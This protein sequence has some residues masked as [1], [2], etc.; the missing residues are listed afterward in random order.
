MMIDRPD[1]KTTLIGNTV[2][3]WPTDEDVERALR[4]LEA[5]RLG[6]RGP[7]SRQAMRKALIAGRPPIGG[8]W[9]NNESN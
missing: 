6:S 1:A 3:C 9:I 7:I 5:A 8:I 2:E 4:A